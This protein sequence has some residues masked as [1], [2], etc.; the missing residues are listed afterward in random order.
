M[1]HNHTQRFSTT[2]SF[3][4]TLFTPTQPFI[5]GGTRKPIY[6]N[7]RY[8]TRP[9]PPPLVQQQQGTTYLSNQR[10]STRAT[11]LPSPPI[12]QQQQ[13]QQ[14][15]KASQQRFA[16]RVRPFHGN[17]LSSQ[18]TKNNNNNITKPQDIRLLYPPTYLPQSHNTNQRYI[19]TTPR[20][21]FL[22][23]H[24]SIRPTYNAYQYHYPTSSSDSSS[25]SYSSSSST[26]TDKFGPLLSNSETIPVAI[27]LS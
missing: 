4:T 5:G 8:S 21:P 26:I 6:P 23:Q 19:S 17:T 11:P 14:H 7:Q 10:Y 18:E 9:L 16:T 13:Q 15:Q 1:D 24:D 20:R 22:L 2:S 27:S 12:Q 25:S 3:R